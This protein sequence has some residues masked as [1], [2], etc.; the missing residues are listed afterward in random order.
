MIIVG[1]CQ[2]VRNQ[3]VQCI[4][5]E[6]T[7]MPSR[8]ALLTQPTQMCGWEWVRGV[9]FGCPSERWGSDQNRRISPRGIRVLLFLLLLLL[10]PVVDRRCD[11]QWTIVSGR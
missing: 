8:F 10:P 3:V 11:E 1:L 9:A 7:E 5:L 6:A 2:A 4:R